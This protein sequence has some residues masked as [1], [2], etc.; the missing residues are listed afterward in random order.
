[1][2][3]QLGDAGGEL[4]PPQPAPC[5]TIA[6]TIWS[7][8]RMTGLS[9]LI[10]PC[11][12]SAMSRSRVC[13]SSASPI[14]SRSLPSSDTRPPTIRAGGRVSRIS[15]IAIVVL[16]EPDSPMSPS[17]SPGRSANETSLT[18]FAGPSGVS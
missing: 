15:A 12:T 18:A 17:R 9:E 7:P 2:R 3:K 16:P 1:M 6:S 14:V 11:G 13:R 4:G 8:R 10:A 5:A